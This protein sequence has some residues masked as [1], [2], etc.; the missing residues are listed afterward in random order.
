MKKGLMLCLLAVTLSIYACKHEILNPG[1][2]GGGGTPPPGEVCFDDVLP[3]FRSSCAKS[4]CH[5]A[6]SK[7]EGYVLDS[8]ANIVKKGIRAG[9]AGRSDIYKVLVEP[10]EDDRM[11]MAPYP[12]LLPDQ[13][14]LIRTWINQGAKNTTG[15]ST[16]ACDTAVFTFTAVK[17]MIDANCLNCH[18][19][20]TASGGLNFSTYAQVKVVAD[21]GKLLGAISHTP[22]YSPMPMGN[23][24]LSDC[25]VTQ[26]RKWI[27]AGAPNN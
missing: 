15:C 23:P 26:V 7:Q 6:V 16:S 4:G 5:D 12:R 22:G 27:L 10:D 1:T 14:A 13:I 24:K 18:S 8:Y 21:N 11:P 19:G 9:D 2:V 25:Q 3:I 17:K 20:A